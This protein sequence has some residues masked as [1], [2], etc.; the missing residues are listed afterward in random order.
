MNEIEARILYGLIGVLFGIVLATYVLPAIRMPDMNSRIA[1]TAEEVARE[2][3]GR[4]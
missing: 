4:R 1:I 3:A 2:K